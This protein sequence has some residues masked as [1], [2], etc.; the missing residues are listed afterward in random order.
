VPTSPPP[1]A[2]RRPRT[3]THFDDERVDDYF[4]LRDRDDAE[5]LAYLTSENEY[6]VAELASTEGL[7]RSIYDEIVA[8]IEETDVTAPVRWGPWWYYE[9][10][11]ESKSYPVHCRRP[12]DGVGFPTQLDGPGE[13]VLLD[14]N[15]LAQGH[16]FCSVGVLE[17]DPGHRL[18]AVGVDF[19]GSERHTVSFLSLDGAPAPPETIEDVGY[20]VAWSADASSLLYVRVDEAWRP[21]ELWRHEL[22]T[23]AAD[24]QLVYREDDERFRVTVARSRDDAVLLVH[25]GSTLTTEVH[26]L[27]ATSTGPLG[28]LWPRRHGVECSIEH[29]TAPDGSTWWI[30]TTNDAGAT[31]FKVLAARVGAAPLAFRELVAERPGRRLNG[32]DAFAHHLVVS[33]RRDGSA[34]VRLLP[35][36]DGPDPFGQDLEARGIDVGSDEDPATT[37]L[38]FTPQYDTEAVRVMQTT[39]VSPFGSFDVAL[40]DGARTLRKRQIVRG[41]YDS[42]RL[43][44]SR[45]WVTA[46]DGV[47]IPVSIVHRRDLLGAGGVPGDPPAA[48]MPLVLYGYGAYE[49]SIDPV[50]SSARLS[51]LDRGVGFAIAH[52]RGGGE[53]GR[54]WYQAGCLEHKVTSFLDFVDVAHAL[55]ERGFSDREHLAAIGGSAGGLLMGAS[56]NLDPTAFRA[57]VA[58]VPFVDVL[59][60]MLDASLPLTVGEW[61]EW[62][63]PVHDPDAYH[64][65]KSWSPYDNVA[66]HEPDGTP[67]RYPD[68]LVLAS[69]NDTRV[70]YW[71]PAKWVAKLRA[72]NPSNR[73]ALKTDLGAGHAGPSGRYDA[74]RERALVFAW[75]TERLGAA[76]TDPVAAG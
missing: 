31:D 33:E 9:R 4:W 58:E 44:S 23:D 45:L 17:V 32:V 35:L 74:W 52:V 6:A 1:A 7:R 34:A 53:L 65:M 40:S 29:L 13:Q 10:T 70:Q 59:S 21:F 63:D 72:A 14:E 8:R 51:L 16:D 43:V 61:E 49:I 22:W 68:L 27:D 64:R 18:C 5:V 30:A 38:G 25:V 28:V 41:G 60:T 73:I 15:E 42:S 2:P 47:D 37:T 11:F 48:P 46:R 56:V 75:V 36:L 24:D 3:L 55:V 71:E 39:L 69:L 12:A 57:V 62:G 50:F 67:R 19:E 54:S 26:V 76:V 66:A 20:A